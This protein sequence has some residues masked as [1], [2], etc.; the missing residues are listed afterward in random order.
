MFRWTS[1]AVLR[2]QLAQ[3]RAYVVELRATV[4]AL[5]KRLEMPTDGLDVPCLTCKG[6]G[7]APR[8]VAPVVPR[9]AELTVEQ[10]FERFRRVCRCEQCRKCGCGSWE[11]HHPATDIVD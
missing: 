5:R 2:G 10:V 6:T 8:F 3:Q 7:Q 1:R 9:P 11:M 4:R